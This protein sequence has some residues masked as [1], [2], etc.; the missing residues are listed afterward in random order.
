MILACRGGFLVLSIGFCASIPTRADNIDYY[1][2]ARMR[3][4]HIPG[5][6]LAIVRA[7]RIT[8]TQVYVFANLELSAHATKETVYEIGKKCSLVDRMAITNQLHLRRRCACS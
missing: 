7:G 4:L 2:S 1:V 6:S 5:P 3:P 8:K